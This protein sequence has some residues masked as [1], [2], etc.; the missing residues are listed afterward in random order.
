MKELTPLAKYSDGQPRE[1]VPELKTNYKDPAKRYELAERMIWSKIPRW[2]QTIIVQCK[3][4]GR[5]EGER[6]LDEYAHEIVCL[7]ESE[8]TLNDKL[9]PVPAFTLESEAEETAANPS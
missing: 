9:P 4:T 2:K 5:L 8:A 1:I 3:L 7:A 6:I